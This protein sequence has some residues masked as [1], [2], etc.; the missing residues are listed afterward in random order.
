MLGEREFEEIL[1]KNKS[2]KSKAEFPVV[3]YLF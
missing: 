1:E 3:E 2:T